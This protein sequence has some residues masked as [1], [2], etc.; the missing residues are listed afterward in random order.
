MLAARGTLPLPP[1]Q[2]AQ[3]L[4][5]LLADAD[6]E[7]SARARQSLEAL[8]PAIVEATLSAPV[9]PD[10]LDWLAER[11][12]E[13]E[14]HLERV[15]L[16]PA[17]S[18][19]TLC[20]LATLPFPRVLDII[21]NNQTRLLRCPALIEALGENSLT[22]QSV[23]D[24]ILQFLSIE[25]GTAA[26][27][28]DPASRD[29]AAEAARLIEAQEVP[30]ELMEDKPAQEGEEA[31]EE[32]RENLWQMLLEMGTMQKIKLALF[33]NGEARSLLVRD[34]NRIVATAVL[35][36]PKLSEKE[37]AAIAK[38]RTV[39]DEVIRTIANGREWT[40]L[41]TVQLALVTNPKTPAQTAIKFLN[42]LTDRDL[43]QIMR[44]RDVPG[45]IS[46][47]ARR[48]LTRKGKL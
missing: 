28:A 9:H 41:Y 25:S 44:S 7:V 4:F 34:R 18:D 16:N 22:G 8:P 10:L 5:A 23:I 2:I 45:Q 27:A 37:V 11:A 15:A 3:V 39:C 6:G 40:R 17:A 21:S 19:A 48:I 38:S 32:I 43:R 31:S 29:A 14:A 30:A 13:N 33:G 1:P 12:R 42:Y 35:R 36:S 26:Q 46:S 24:R 20:R 47:Q